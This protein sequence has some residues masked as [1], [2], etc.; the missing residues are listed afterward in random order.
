MK[1]N[2]TKTKLE[3]KIKKIP[4]KELIGGLAK[5]QKLQ[6]GKIFTDRMF[7]MHY[8]PATGWQDAVIKKYENFSISP[9]A[10]VLHYAQEIFEGLKAYY[11]ADGHIGLFRARDN[12]LRMNISAE[13]LCL[14]KIDVDFVLEALRKLLTMEKNWVPQ[15]EGSSLYI[16]PTLIGID[17]YIGLHSSEECLFYIIM[18]P[19]GMYYANGFEPVRIMVEE[20]YVRAVRGGIGFAKTGGNY[21]ASIF[22][23]EEA[24]KKGFDQV[25]WLDGVQQ[26]YV[27]EVGSMNI[28]FKYRDKL[29]TSALNG[30][31]LAGIT[32]DSVLKIAKLWGLETKEETLDINQI[33]QDIKS[34]QITEVFGAGTA[35]VI[36]PVGL[37]HYRGENIE[38]NK[39]S[40]G[41][42]TRK[43]YDYLTGIQCGKIADPFGWTEV[44]A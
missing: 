32:R 11:R 12:F 9:A 22:T 18:S 19:V 23:G 31:I 4:G 33:V 28:F 37:L 35:A 3:I 26:K 42:L 5:G 1:T 2:M 34:G 16:R 7:Q 27:E 24:Q 38:I 10:A 8:T 30:S 17:P 44:V 15:Q 14:P 36:S 29:V 13:R 43:L 21:A 40:V 41:E 39:Q 6:F 25:L 20:K